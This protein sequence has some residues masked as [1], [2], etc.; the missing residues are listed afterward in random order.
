MDQLPTH[1]ADLVTDLRR[2]MSAADSTEAEV[3]AKV[4]RE[5]G[6]ADAAEAKAAAAE[7][8]FAAMLRERDALA[9]SATCI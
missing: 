8:R 2:A 9:V 3:E 6:R 4:I 5:K 7:Q 1:V